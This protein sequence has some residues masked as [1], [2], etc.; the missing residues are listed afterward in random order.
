MVCL[1][2]SGEFMGIVKSPDYAMCERV[3]QTNVGGLVQSLTTPLL[4][5]TS[6]LKWNNVLCRAGSTVIVKG[7]IDS[8][9]QYE[10]ITFVP[11]EDIVAL[12]VI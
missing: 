1:C 2:S 4:R 9:A 6:P 12:V 8:Y 10:A 11:L 3:S 7:E 5:L